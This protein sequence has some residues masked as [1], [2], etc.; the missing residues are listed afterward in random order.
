MSLYAP[1]ITYVGGNK[2]NFITSITYSD[3]LP[4]KDLLSNLKKLL[5]QKNI[6]EL[7]GIDDFISLFNTPG[8][9]E[10]SGPAFYPVYSIMEANMDYE[11]PS[12]SE[13]LFERAMHS[14]TSNTKRLYIIREKVCS[15]C[16]F[17][18]EAISLDEFAIIIIEGI[19]QATCVL[20]LHSQN[21]FDIRDGNPRFHGIYISQAQK[22]IDFSE[23]S[24]KLTF[25]PALGSDSHSI[26][27]IGKENYDIKIRGTIKFY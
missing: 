17:D 11:Y 5:E 10:I 27:L 3:R 19:R 1:L 12:P 13:E 23:N 21:L 2:S 14:K 18:L 25:K 4:T 22:I 15:S 24:N 8:T 7:A 16:N 26:S 20:S 6:S 9:K